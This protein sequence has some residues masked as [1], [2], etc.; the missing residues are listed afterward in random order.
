MI[1]TDGAAAARLGYFVLPVLGVAWATATD[2]IRRE[3]PDWI[4]AGLV[5]WAILAESLG[6]LPFPWTSLILGCATGLLVGAIGF[7]LRSLGGGDVKLLA[8]LGAA[9]GFSAVW[10]LLFWTALAGG[11]LGLIAKARG[12]PELAFAPAIA[13]GLLAVIVSETWA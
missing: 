2:L 4:P 11:I 1:S 10:T 13:A 5:L 7:R 6:F 9:I 3:I 8:G 12:E